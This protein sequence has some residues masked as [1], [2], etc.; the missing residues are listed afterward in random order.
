MR[1]LE[2]GLFGFSLPNSKGE[3]SA[4]GEVEA[5]VEKLGGTEMGEDRDKMAPKVEQEPWGSPA[6]M[7][8]NKVRLLSDS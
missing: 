2:G 6:G 4:V 3:P 1:T 7:S 8:Q 5:S